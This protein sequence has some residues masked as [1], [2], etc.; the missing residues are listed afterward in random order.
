MEGRN[1]L[2]GER[3]GGD[4]RLGQGWAAQPH[5]RTPG[6]PAPRW[7]L[8]MSMDGL[9]KQIDAA[10]RELHNVK[11]ED[12]P[13]FLAAQKAKWQAWDVEQQLE[14]ERFVDETGLQVHAG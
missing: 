3:A 7:L 5:L 9:Q 1:P 4:A 2:R 13:R 10:V 11:R 8:Q 12:L 6:A 14:W